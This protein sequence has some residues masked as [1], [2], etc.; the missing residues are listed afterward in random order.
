MVSEHDT[1]WEDLLGFCPKHGTFIKTSAW[2]A[3]LCKECHV[4]KKYAVYKNE[5]HFRHEVL[6]TRGV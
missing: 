4:G 2:P 5:K 6:V 1:D 3:G